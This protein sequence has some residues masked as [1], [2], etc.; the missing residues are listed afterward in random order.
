[1]TPPFWATS[2][3]LRQ[4]ATSVPNSCTYSMCNMPSTDKIFI[5]TKR[6]QQRYYFSLNISYILIDFLSIYNCNHVIFAAISHWIASN[7]VGP[8][9]ISSNLDIYITATLL[10][11][12]FWSVFKEC[13]K[14]IFI[15]IILISKDILIVIHRTGFKA[16]WGNFR[17][18]FVVSV[19]R[20]YTSPQFFPGVQI[21]CL[22]TVPTLPRNIWSVFTFLPYILTWW[23]L[24]FILLESI[25]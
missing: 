21:H 23:T 6:I 18:G 7:Y 19:G 15:Y 1:M 14:Y 16:D 12:W 9:K 13:F 11:W 20:H 4:W 22:E 2:T 25:F 24:H 3:F 5:F 10:Q 17:R 8:L